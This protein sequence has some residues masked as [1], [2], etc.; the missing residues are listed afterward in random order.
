[1]LA[2]VPDAP[3]EERA[4]VL[5]DI[6]A[7]AQ[8]LSRLVGGLLSLARADGGQM[9]A[10]KDLWLDELASE[11][12]ARVAGAHREYSIELKAD[13]PVC[14]R[15]D[16]D[17]LS[18]VLLI[19]LDNAIKY[20]R[21][22]GSVL[23]TVAEVDGRARLTVQDWGIGISTDE[24]PHI[25]E[26]FYRAPRARRHDRGGAGLGL[27]IAGWIVQQHHGHIDVRSTEGEGTTITILLS[28]S[29]SCLPY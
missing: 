23:C 26:R 7:E 24:L 14:V 25:F 9:L 11:V 2:R 4:E 6:I 8:R 20:S 16:P 10:D 12:V 29:R 17:L 13:Q 3:L 1:M 18:E 15:A 27:S 19:L 21:S 22:Y 5:A 28:T